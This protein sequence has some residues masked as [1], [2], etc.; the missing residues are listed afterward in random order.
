MKLTHHAALRA[1]GGHM[2]KDHSTAKTE[3]WTI[4]AS[5]EDTFYDVR[6]TIPFNTLLSGFRDSGFIVY[7]DQPKVTDSLIA[8]APDLLAALENA[9]NVLA[10]IATG[11]L[12][13]IGKDSPALLQ[14][15]AAI[16][17]AKG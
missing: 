15:R 13:T 7:M 6:D 2:S 10:G 5:S 16:A 1:I 4:P 17:K 12:D 14:A 3:Y 11:D 8:A 9:A